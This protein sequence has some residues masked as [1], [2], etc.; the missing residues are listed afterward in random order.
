MPELGQMCFS[1]TEWQAMEMQP[2]VEQAL[3]TLGELIEQ[4]APKD[5][6]GQACDP[7]SNS[8]TEFSCPVFTARSY[9]WC[10]GERRRWSSPAHARTAGC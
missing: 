6:Y 5:E 2:H 4:F 10:D 3:V 1:N 8:G 7:M 9:C